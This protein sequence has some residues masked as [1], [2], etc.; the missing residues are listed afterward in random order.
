MVF[1]GV[2]VL[3]DSLVVPGII[4]DPVVIYVPGEISFPVVGHSDKNCNYDYS[5]SLD[6][7]WARRHLD[8]SHDS[9]A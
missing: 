8:S 5:N 7:P 9:R 2:S 6:Q 4:V 3:V 1:L